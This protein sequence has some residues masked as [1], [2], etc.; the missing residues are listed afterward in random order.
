MH[1]VVA[2][3]LARHRR[4]LGDAELVVELGPPEAFQP[5]ALARRDGLGG[6]ENLLY[7]TGRK[8]DAQAFGVLGELQRVARHAGDHGRAQGADQL[9]LE[10][11]GRVVARPAGH[12]AGAELLRGAGVGEADGVDAE[13][14]AD[15]DQIARSAAGRGLEAPE[16]FHAVAHVG[17]R[18]RVEQRLSGHAAGTPVFD[19]R[20]APGDAE[21]LVEG[22]GGEFAQLVLGEDRDPAPLLGIVKP[23]RVDTVETTGE[24]AREPGAFDGD[25]QTFALD[26]LDLVPRAW[27]RERVFAFGHDRPSGFAERAGPFPQHEFLDLAGGG[28]GQVAEHHR[29]R[30]LEMGEIAAA[31]GDDVRLGRALLPPSG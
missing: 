5:F 30:S 19:H 25:R 10:R 6:G 4:T 21:I 23:G 2:L 26:R 1:A 3:A 16:P 15:M 20:I 29:L 17:R 12:H 31:K 18:A 13:R 14:E 7:R 8:V 11:G 24:E 9:E 22:L 27:Q 28:L